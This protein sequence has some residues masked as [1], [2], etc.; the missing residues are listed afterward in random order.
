MGVLV[1]ESA[2][3][4]DRFSRRRLLT[5]AV[6]GSLESFLAL[7]GLRTLSVRLERAQTNASELAQRL[8]RHPAV[9]RVHYPGLPE[10]PDSDRIAK[11]LSGP[12]ALM[13]FELTGTAERADTVCAN[14]KLISDAT[15]LGGVESLMERRARHPGE[16][17]QDTPE[18]L[19][20]L[21]VG[22][23]HIED[24]W[25]DLDQALSQ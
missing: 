9:T 12:G 5:G 10:H 7:R 23:E 11:L 1:A 6:P 25:A 24:L 21:S 13:C 22:I 4:V 14:V 8:Q 17:E 3:L 15:S 16:V 19:I 18:T 2:D 20:R